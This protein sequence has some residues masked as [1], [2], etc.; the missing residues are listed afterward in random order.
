MIPKR[1]NLD[2][3][4]RAIKKPQKF[5]DEVN[6]LKFYLK[7]RTYGDDF[8]ME[9]WDNLIILDACRYD[10]FRR[11]NFIEGSLEYRISKGST[12]WPFMKGNYAG[13]T[14]H[15]TVYVTGNL[16]TPKLENDIFH[17][18]I[19]VKV[20]PISEGGYTGFPDES[21]AVLPETVTKEAVAASKQ[22]PNKRLITHYMQP[23]IAYLGE[24]GREIYNKLIKIKDELP[25][26]LSKDDRGGV[27]HILPRQIMNNGIVDIS[28][29]MLW[30]AYLEN[31]DIVLEHVDT[32]VDELDGK[33]V[34]TAD[35]GELI[36]EKN[37]YG[38]LN[39][40]C[41][42]LRKV[43]WHVIDRNDRR[44]I[45]AEAPET[46]QELDEDEIKEQLRVLGYA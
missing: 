1:Y 4:F 28:E 40:L 36:G 10:A 34:I 13:K 32:L 30:Q 27:A 22:Y 31:L 25:Y 8:I 37:S 6:R 20:E 17:A 11:R 21:Y 15:D 7:Y 39:I 29:E 16:H 23:H 35:H 5:V 12:S 2:S 3:L 46:R 14:L 18:L 44:E 26:E 45:I 33:T 43:P 38:H 19:P 41:E 24:T 9:D 42:E